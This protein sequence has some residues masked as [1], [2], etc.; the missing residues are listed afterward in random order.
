MCDD[1]KK[2]GTKIAIIGK[3]SIIE[4]KE[5]GKGVL[6]YFTRPIPI[7]GRLS[8]SLMPMEVQMRM[9]VDVYQAGNC[10]SISSIQKSSLKSDIISNE[11]N[12][13]LSRMTDALLNEIAADIHNALL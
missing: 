6:Q 11:L 2:S 5:Q 4:I 7:I 3:D 10:V 12:E 13:E 9:A 8:D 1:L